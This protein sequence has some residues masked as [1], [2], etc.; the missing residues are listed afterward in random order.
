MTICS[1]ETQ[2]FLFVKPYKDNMSELYI[3]FII[4]LHYAIYIDKRG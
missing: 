1:Y 2:Y 4:T 3:F